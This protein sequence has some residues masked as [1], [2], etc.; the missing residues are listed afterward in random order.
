M[1]GERGLS[2][3]VSVLMPTYN[4]AHLL[5]TAVQSVLDQTYHDFELLI[6]DDGSED[7]T[8]S[9]ISAFG[10]RRIRYLHQAHRGISAALNRGLRA[11][12]GRYVAR[13]DSDDT[14]VS[15]MLETQVPVLDAGIAGVVYARARGMDQA[16]RSLDDYR[17]LPLRYAGRSLESLLYGD[18]TCNIT[19]VARRDCLQRAGPYD[20]TLSVNEDWHMWLRVARHCQFHFTDQILAQYRYHDGNVTGES[21]PELSAHLDGR[22]EV[23]DRFYALPN[24]PKSALAMKPLA[25]RNAYLWSASSWRGMGENRRALAMYWRALAVGGMRLDTLARILWSNLSGV[26][27][28]LPGAGGL[29]RRVRDKVR[30][31]DSA[32]YS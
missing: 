2:P 25:Y 3:K 13:L 30:A 28:R 17:G 24:L 15:T 19:I 14:W 7:D 4:R 22:S 1:S 18:M 23:L 31:R 12:R 5:C 6:V 8:R 10:D 29:T 32:G 26:V 21:S 16:G 11:A 9:R 20:E 27:A